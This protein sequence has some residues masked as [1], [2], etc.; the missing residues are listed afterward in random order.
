MAHTTKMPLWRFL[1]VALVTHFPDRHNKRHSQ[2]PSHLQLSPPGDGFVVQ[3]ASP[4]HKRHN[5]NAAGILLFFGEHEYSGNI[6]YS[7]N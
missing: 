5:K 4:N 7:V 2:V 3:A 1:L 6:N